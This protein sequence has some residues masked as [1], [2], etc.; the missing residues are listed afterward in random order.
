MRYILLLLLCLTPTLVSANDRFWILWERYHQVGPDCPNGANCLT[1][2]E[3]SSRPL[4]REQSANIYRL[5]GV[6]DPRGFNGASDQPDPNA[7]QVCDANDANLKI[8]FD[9]LAVPQSL[10]V[11]ALRGVK[12]LHVDLTRLKAAPGHAQDFGAK[13]HRAFVAKLAAAGL[14]VVDEE[15]I[16]TIPGQPTLN[17]FFSFN[18]PD[19]HCDYE[20]SVFA[21]LSQ[22][23]M[24]ARDI[25]IKIHTGV[26][27]FSTGSSDT[28][29]RGD[30]RAAI[31]K[32]ADALIRDHRQVNPR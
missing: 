3:F 5:F 1:K 28:N 12:A 10:K 19:G 26:W 27:A 25:R 8:G 30:E 17:I 22:D 32:V 9:P 31:L 21:S 24:L 13:V 7:P 16:R 2:R 20:Y 15:S 18:D 23:V 29:H 6:M 4:P 11:E 14:R